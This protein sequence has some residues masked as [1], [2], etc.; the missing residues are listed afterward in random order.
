[1]VLFGISMNARTELKGI[2]KDENFRPTVTLYAAAIG[3]EFVLIY[4][5]IKLHRIHLMDNFHFDEGMLR[6]DWPA[7][8][9]DKK[10]IWYMLGKRVANRL[11]PPE[12]ILKLKISLL[13]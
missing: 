3:N 6:M 2:N 13:Q 4:K 7:Y 10:H 5:N 8:F 1:M 9:P 11:L 12:S